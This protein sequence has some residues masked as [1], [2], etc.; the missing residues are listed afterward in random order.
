MEFQRV[1]H[2][3]RCIAGSRPAR[4]PPK[5]PQSFATNI[6]IFIANIPSRSLRRPT[7]GGQ[8]EIQ[9]APDIAYLYLVLPVVLISIVPISVAG[10]GAREGAMVAAFAYAGLPQS[11]GLII[12]LL[13]GAL[14]LIFG[15][16]GGVV[17]VLSSDRVD[18]NAASPLPSLD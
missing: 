7:A 2:P 9:C 5:L 13:F 16:A 15:A 12:S 3:S 10:W 1:A 14:Y 4:L 11:D 17:W 18:R 8:P 6:A